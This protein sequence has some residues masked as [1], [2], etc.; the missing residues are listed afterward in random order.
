MHAAHS[1]EPQCFQTYFCKSVG[2]HL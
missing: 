2:I 1:R